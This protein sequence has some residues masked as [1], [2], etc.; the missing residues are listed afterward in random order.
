MAKRET[1]MNDITG[2]RDKNKVFFNTP[3]EEGG[4]ITPKV[5]FNLQGIDKQIEDRNNY[6]ANIQAHS[7]LYESFTPY[8][9]ILVRVYLRELKLAAGKIFTGDSAGFDKIQIPSSNVQ[10]AVW[11]TVD[12]PFPF[13]AKCVVVATPPHITNFSKGDVLAIPQLQALPARKGDDSVII[14]EH[15][16]VHPDS[17]SVLPVQD[18]TNENFGYAII[19]TSIIQGFLK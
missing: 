17:G 1:T 5:D 6:N 2:H 3:R 9:G 16:F 19:P 13:A 18:F 10:G 7:R 12:N 11:R 14:Y 15:F 8:Q 4:L